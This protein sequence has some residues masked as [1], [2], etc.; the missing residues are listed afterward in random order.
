MKQS[1]RKCLV[2]KSPQSAW[3]HKPQSSLVRVCSGAC[4]LAKVRSDKARADRKRSAEQAS[5]TRADRERLKTLPMLTKECQQAFNAWVRE[6]DRGKPCI[7]CGKDSAGGNKFITGSGFDCG[8]FRSVGSAPHHRFNPNN[9]HLQCV[10]DNQF[11]SGAIVEYRKGLIERIGL[12]AVEAL[13]ADNEPRKYSKDD[14]RAMRD[15]YRRRYREL[16]KQNEA[17]AV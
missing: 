6:R 12:D 4:A 16:K 17:R 11:L 8:H 7:S 13:E 15:D 1:R 10:R 2:C 3:P 14:L 9:A 5:R